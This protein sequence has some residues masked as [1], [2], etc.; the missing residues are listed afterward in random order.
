MSPRQRRPLALLAVALGTFMTYLDNNV[1]NVAIPTIERALHLSESG[2]EWV[3]SSYILVFAGLLLA[4][5]RLADV[6]G[7]RRLFSGGLVLFTLASMLAGAAPNAAV[8]ITGRALQG[9]GA[10]MLTPTTL[11]IVTATYEEP[12][13]RDR[14]IGIWGAV[15]AL[16]LAVGPVIG[17]SLAEHVS[18]HWIFF[19]NGPVGVITL[20]LGLWAIPADTAE[21]ARHLDWRGVATSAVALLALTFALIE[22]ERNGWSSAPILAAFAVTALAGAAFLAVERRVEDPMIELSLF[23]DRRFSGALVALMLWAF[24]LFGIYFFTSLY[25]QDVLSFSPTVAGAAFVPMALLMAV[26]ATVSDRVSARLGVQRVVGAAMVAMALGIVSV[27]LLGPHASFAELM[28]GFAI[29]GI[30][31]GLTI[32]LTSVVAGTMAPER[33]GVASAIFNASRE[34][35]GLLGITV[36]GVVLVAR[37]SAAAHLGT[38]PVTAF[39][40]GY[41]LGLVVAGALVAAGGLVAWSTLPS[42]AAGAGRVAAA[43]LAA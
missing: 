26:G 40:D 11:A 30:G 6:V 32:P 9:L 41:R 29:I 13:E 27:S 43:G 35:A 8:L 33:A 14:A 10:A 34:V 24:G 31:G 20:A 12:A 3:V 38:A 2:I 39:L 19:L 1:V 22:G 23:S 5:G 18:W 7:R 42:R 36:I 37:Q 16:A 21:R 28:P 17:G 15:G 4:G 25:L